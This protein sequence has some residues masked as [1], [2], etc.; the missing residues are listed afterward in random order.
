MDRGQELNEVLKTL[1]LSAEV[2]RYI[3][4]PPYSKYWVKLGST[5][6]LKKLES[7]AVEIGLSMKS[8]APIC[9]PDWEEG[10]VCLE[11]MNGSH[12]L[13]KFDELVESS[14]FGNPENVLTRYELPVLLGT[15][16]VSEPVIVDLVKFPHVLV[17]GT[18]GSGK[19]VCEH[20]IFQSLALHAKINRVK[21]VLIDPKFV[22]FTAYR[23]SPHL[24]YDIA[25]KPD[26]VESILV[27]LTNVMNKRLE[28]LQ[29]N[30][31]RD[32]AEYRQ[33]KGK[34][35]Y[36]V[37]LIDELSDLMQTTKKRFE[38]ALCCLAQKGRAA[39]IHLVAATQYPHSDVLTGKI[40]ANFDGRICFRV[41]DPAH[42]RVV[43]GDKNSGAVH[44]EGKGDGYLS[45]G[46]YSLQRF[47]GA[48]VDM[49][50][51]EPG[52]LSRVSAAFAPSIT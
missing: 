26:V 6:T 41:T 34:G 8:S 14:G 51:P 44:L 28:T 11:M 13:I 21:F 32:M 2:I 52:L 5:G 35:S 24:M 19:S 9:M 3:D 25:T 10:A 7:K 38:E 15:K 29:K 33:K 43:L 22:E 36:I 42:S 18:T 23:K 27:D 16:N 20:A 31:C 50:K 17:S 40:K 39:G 30:G 37:I 1:K 4:T 49:K 48:L 46:A 45:G 12:P 47:R